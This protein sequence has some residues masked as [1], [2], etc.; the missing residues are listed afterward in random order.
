[1]Y[2]LSNKLFLFF[3]ETMSYYGSS[4][5][6]GDKSGIYQP[7]TYP[8]CNYLLS[9]TG[10]SPGPGQPQA[11]APVS[12]AYAAMAT[13]PMYSTATAYSPL[14]PTFQTA[15]AAQASANP[16]AYSRMPYTSITP[17]SSTPG[18]PQTQYAAPT[19]LGSQAL[20]ASNPGYPQSA[21]V[22]VTRSMIYPTSAYSAAIPSVPTRGYSPM[23]YPAS[24]LPGAAPTYPVTSPYRPPY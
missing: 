20:G 22:A 9:Q 15:A 1:M 6:N 8:P 16:S 12:Q 17:I 13:T 19:Y 23:G 24:Q 11:Y 3:P 21:P 7:G 4:I 10:F 2:N 5:P 14:S 18:Y